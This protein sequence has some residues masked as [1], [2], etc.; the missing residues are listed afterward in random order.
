MSDFIIIKVKGKGHHITVDGVS[1]SELRELLNQLEKQDPH[2]LYYLQLFKDSSYSLCKTGDIG[3]KDE[4]LMS[5]EGV[6][7]E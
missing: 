7:W 2:S 4:Y 3:E 6:V 5:G 1:L